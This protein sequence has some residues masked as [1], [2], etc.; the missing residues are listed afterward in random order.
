MDDVQSI[1]SIFVFVIVI[2]IRIIKENKKS[3]RAG[4]RTSGTARTTF[5]PTIQTT[6][7]TVIDNPINIE[8]ETSD[9]TA[10]TTQPQIEPQPKAHVVEESNENDTD[11]SQHIEKWRQAI[12]T[13]EILKTKF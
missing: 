10:I 6:Q 8:N 7:P 4:T 9:N 3:G 13:S 1:I 2:I 5:R 12:I 11:N